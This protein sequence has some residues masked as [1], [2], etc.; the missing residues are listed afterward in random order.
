MTYSYDRSAG[1]SE[2]E[3]VENEILT[4]EVRKAIDDFLKLV[5][6]QGQAVHH[7]VD[8]Q[9]DLAT[10]KVQG[11]DKISKE[12]VLRAVAKVIENRFGDDPLAKAMARA[13]ALGDGLT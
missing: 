13:I 3:W 1:Q 5:L 4:E 9:W 8:A 11:G 2:V 7:Q 12:D 10:K 6:R